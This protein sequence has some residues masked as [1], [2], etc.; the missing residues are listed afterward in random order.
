MDIAFTQHGVREIPGPKAH[1]QIVEYHA[2]T[3]LSSSSDEVP[4]C[5]AFANWCMLSAH[6]RGTGSAA[7]R[8]W[9]DWGVPIQL[10]CVVVLQSPQRG[11]RAGHVAFFWMARDAREIWLYGGNHDNT[12]GLKS[13]PRADV[14]GYRWPSEHAQ[15]SET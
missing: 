15:T 9:L 8:S 10:G 12:V 6:I 11:P 5:S 1:P 3:S 4:W 14:I 2:T 7:A 13:Y